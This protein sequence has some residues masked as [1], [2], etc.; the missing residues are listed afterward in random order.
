MKR[1]LL[2]L[3]LFCSV[4]P[5]TAAEVSPEELTAIPAVR[6]VLWTDAGQDGPTRQFLRSLAGAFTERYPHITFRVVQTEAGSLYERF[7]AAY[8][9][10]APPDLLWATGEQIGLCAAAGLLQPVDALLEHSR[11]ATSALA[12]VQT[13]GATWGVPF[14]SGTYLAVTGDLQG[15][16]LTA[17]AGFLQFAA[18]ADAR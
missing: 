9:V 6:L 7:T 14:G 10:V 17:A 16:W 18:G 12:P 3:L 13:G 5:F 8:R 1:R 11:F 2:P 4:Q 15:F